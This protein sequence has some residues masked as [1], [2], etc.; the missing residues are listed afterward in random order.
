MRTA[1]KRGAAQ[2]EPWSQKTVVLFI[3]VNVSILL[4]SIGVSFILWSGCLACF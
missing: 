1:A 4:I 3:F 2:E